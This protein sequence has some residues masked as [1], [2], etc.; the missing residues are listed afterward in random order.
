MKIEETKFK[1]IECDLE[2]GGDHIYGLFD[3]SEPSEE[4]AK[5]KRVQKYNY[6]WRIQVI[7][8]SR[9]VKQWIG[10]NKDKLNYRYIYNLS[11]FTNSVDWIYDKDDIILVST[12][13]LVRNYYKNKR[14][15]MIN[16]CYLKASETDVKIIKKGEM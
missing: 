15:Q 10:K 3:I 1:I 6:A 11:I 5:S 8:M 9:G 14:G 4:K 13:V 7:E 16:D 12:P 2:I